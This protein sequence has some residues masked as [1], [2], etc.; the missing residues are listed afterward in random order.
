MTDDMKKM[1]VY[2]TQSSDYVEN[3]TK[4]HNSKDLK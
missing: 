2:E 3:E 4:E 1:Q